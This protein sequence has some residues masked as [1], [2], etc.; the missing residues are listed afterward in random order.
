VKVKKITDMGFSKAEAME[1]LRACAYNEEVAGNMLMQ[2][3]F[4]TK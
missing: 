3:K 1:T 4:G 2:N